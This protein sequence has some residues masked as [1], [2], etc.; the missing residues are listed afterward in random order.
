MA[1]EILDAII[2]ESP[3]KHTVEH[4]IESFIWVLAYAVMRKILKA[5][6]APETASHRAR[7]RLDDDYERSFGGLD[8]VV[9]IISSRTS[10]SPLKFIIRKNQDFLSPYL[11]SPLRDLLVHL[12]A[13]LRA[14]IEAPAFDMLTTV[15]EGDGLQA[16]ETVALTH[17]WLINYFNG[18]IRAL[19]SNLSLQR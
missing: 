7:E 5:T 14:R 11:S 16:P 2:D 4:D 8:S 1:I 12:R 10:L 19:E 18:A 17:T 9:D 15:F 3:V 13:S 6:E